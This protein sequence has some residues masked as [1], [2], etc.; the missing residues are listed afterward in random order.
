MKDALMYTRKLSLYKS[1]ERDEASLK[2]S[3]S[4]RRLKIDIA[5]TSKVLRICIEF[6][7]RTRGL[8]E[9]CFERLQ[10]AFEHLNKLGIAL[11]TM[12]SSMYSASPILIL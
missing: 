8:I 3:S 9:V 11:H 4:S 2:K 6:M 10:I 7:A 5:G 12:K 1:E